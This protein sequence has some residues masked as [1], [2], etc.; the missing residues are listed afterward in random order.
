MPLLKG[1]G[2]KHFFSV[3][4]WRRPPELLNHHLEGLMK[5]WQ[6]RTSSSHTDD[7]PVKN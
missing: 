7:T 5:P 3:R 6:L 4:F 2:I 1:K